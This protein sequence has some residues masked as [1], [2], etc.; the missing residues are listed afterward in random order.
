M[1][2][3][4]ILVPSLVPTGPIK[5]AVALA[6]YLVNKTLV[7]IVTVKNSS[8]Y[9]SYL[10]KRINYICLKNSKLGVIGKILE[11]GK[12]LR[13]AGGPG[14]VASISYC[15]SADL[16][17]VFCSKY[18][19]TC[20]SVRGDLIK[21]Y[22]MDHG[23][24]GL[25]AAVIHL[26]SLAKFDKIIAMSTAMSQQIKFYSRKDAFIVGNFIDEK[27]L[28]G[29]RKRKFNCNNLLSRFVFVGNLS[30]NKK[31]LLLIHALNKI[32]SAGHKVALDIIGDGPL[33]K[34]IVDL[35]EKLGLQSIIKV[36]GYLSEPFNVI[37]R[38]DIFVLPSLSEGISRASLEAL[39]LGLPVILRAKDGN[40]ELI[41][42]GYNGI[43]FN[44][45]N[46]LEKALIS[47]LSII[48]KKQDP[49]K[50][51]PKFYSQQYCAKK[52]L[53]IICD[54]DLDR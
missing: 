48:N 19:L 42:H 17:N 36:H 52:Y 10:D 32:H 30:F 23:W 33:K 21:V 49:M 28:K 35:I 3:I 16:I 7:T 51:L 11:F 44:D 12:L 31:P 50:L 38:A 8:R 45:D 29:M 26:T 43:L 14:K 5:G 22:K 54:N 47:A 27:P 41:D 4:F 18:A 2:I 39:Y 40:L 1:K 34:E 25:I 9:S 24:I 15:F 37:V 53:N 6:N 46:D 13:E 20:S